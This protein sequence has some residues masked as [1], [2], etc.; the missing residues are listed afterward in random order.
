MTRASNS[1]F[2][3]AKSVS[4]IRDNITTNPRFA[5]QLNVLF[6]FLY[7]SLPRI[8]VAHFPNSLRFQKRNSFFCVLA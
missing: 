7:V 8:L 4:R 5:I 1:V 2:N 3:V 6:A